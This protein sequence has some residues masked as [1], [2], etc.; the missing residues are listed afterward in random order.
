MLDSGVRGG[1][2]VLRGLTMGADFVFSG[3]S[4]WYAA[5][6]M[7]SAGVPHAFDMLRQELV[8]AM[9]QSGLT[10]IDDLRAKATTCPETT[11]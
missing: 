3:R 1:L 4:F 5:G 9:C 11:P 8:L 7:G 2:D 10:S 6:A